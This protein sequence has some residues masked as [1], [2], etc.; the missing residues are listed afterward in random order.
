MR[1]YGKLLAIE[2]DPESPISEGHLCPKGAASYELLTHAA[3]ELN[4]EVGAQHEN[5]CGRSE[6]QQIEPDA[7]G[8]IHRPQALAV[9]AEHA[10]ADDVYPERQ[11]EQPEAEQPR[12][13]DHFA[14]P[15]SFRSADRRFDLVCHAH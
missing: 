12:R 3:R 9:L 15:R 11:G 8:E 13:D 2:G 1:E 6:G 10:L 4:R 5:P 14:P 7:F